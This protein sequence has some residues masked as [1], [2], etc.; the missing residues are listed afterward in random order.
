M[1]KKQLSNINQ[2]KTIYLFN[3]SKQKHEIEQ[4]NSYK[5]KVNLNEITPWESELLHACF[6]PLFIA[7]FY[8][9]L[10]KTAVMYQFS[11]VIR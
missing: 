7:V 6:Q 10:R 1:I 3:N 5:S 8:Q 11:A 2:I 4:I 9:F